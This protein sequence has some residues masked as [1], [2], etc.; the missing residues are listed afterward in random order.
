M[1]NENWFEN[2][3]VR[4]IGGKITVFDWEG[5]PSLGSSYREVR[6]TDGVI[7]IIIIIIVIIIIVII[8][9]IIIIIIT[10]IIIIIS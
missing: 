8:I 7:I 5:E 10:I 2:R 6:T 3:R 4:K 9:I 1:R